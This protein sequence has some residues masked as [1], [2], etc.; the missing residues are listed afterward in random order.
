MKQSNIKTQHLKINSLFSYVYSTKNIL[1]KLIEIRVTIDLLAFFLKDTMPHLDV[2]DIYL[3]K[4]AILCY[5]FN[6]TIS[7]RYGA[8]LLQKQGKYQ[9][10]YYNKNQ[11]SL[12]K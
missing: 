8:A 4:H 3:L 10:L 11:Q 9:N 6:T 5:L 12:T 7:Y 2:P 1:F